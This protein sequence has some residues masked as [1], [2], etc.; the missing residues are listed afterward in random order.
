MHQVM[1]LAEPKNPKYK[2][3]L[4]TYIAPKVD[5]AKRW[6]KEDYPTLKI[7]KIASLGVKEYEIEA[8][9]YYALYE[10]S[11]TVQARIRDG[12]ETR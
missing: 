6:F 5:M 1:V 8:S 10:E 12:E 2:A 9:K 7:L 3:F 11:Q 4:T